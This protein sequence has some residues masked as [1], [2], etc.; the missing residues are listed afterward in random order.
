[1]CSINFDL[2]V[3]HNNEVG[4]ENSWAL[5]T[6]SLRAEYLY[7]SVDTTHTSQLR[8]LCTQ[9]HIEYLLRKHPLLQVDQRLERLLHYNVVVVLDFPILL[10]KLKV[11]L[12]DLHE[13]RPG[14]VS[15]LHD[16]VLI[17][18]LT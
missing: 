16:H 3:M 18:W 12:R 10:A 4:F 6:I 7:W 17:D 8:R 15:K 9:F 14:I 13:L 11:M 2:G 5:I 1:M